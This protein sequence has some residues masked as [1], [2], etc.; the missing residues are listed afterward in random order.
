MLAAV[1]AIGAVPALSAD[2]GPPGPIPFSGFDRD[3]SGYVSPQEYEAARAQRMQQRAEQQRRFR[4][5]DARPGFGDIDSNGDGRLSREEVEAHHRERY[6]H[7]SSGPWS[8]AGG[9][10]P[11]G[12]GGGKR[13]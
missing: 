6:E 1:L 3:G 8:G 13:Q 2:S 11:P 4:N 5:M 7:R 10:R 9:G 12:M